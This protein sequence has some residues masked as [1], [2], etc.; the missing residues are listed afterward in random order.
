LR[1]KPDDAFA[2]YKLANDLD[3]SGRTHEAVPYYRRS[4]QIDERN[5]HVH[6]N[7]GIALMRLGNMTEA[8]DHFV[9]AIQLNPDLGDAHYNLGLAFVSA[10]R[11]DDAIM[12]FAEALRL[13]PADVESRREME[14]ARMRLRGTRG[15][16]PGP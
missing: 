12:E 3:L 1:I 4:L 9:R 14:S 16:R 5:P 13:N 11:L 6:N 15:G 8:K 2:N 7:L 10:G